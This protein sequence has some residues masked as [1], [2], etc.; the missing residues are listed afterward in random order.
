MKTNELEKE[1]RKKLDYLIELKKV[2]KFLI[3]EITLKEK[4]FNK[5]IGEIDKVYL[6]DSEVVDFILNNSDQIKSIEL[7]KYRFLLN[8]V[9]FNQILKYPYEREYINADFLFVELLRDKLKNHYLSSEDDKNIENISSKEFNFYYYRLLRFFKGYEPLYESLYFDFEENSVS[10]PIFG[11]L[12]KELSL[13]KGSSFS[14]QLELYKNKIKEWINKEL[15]KFAHKD[16]N[17]INQALECMNIHLSV[18][19]LEEDELYLTEIELFE[20]KL[21]IKF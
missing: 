4:I 2:G 3:W 9:I 14:T 1:L 21:N 19:P 17:K 13:L 15:D 10:I 20:K 6:F 7:F 5:K 16:F 18:E 12:E 11:K 8:E